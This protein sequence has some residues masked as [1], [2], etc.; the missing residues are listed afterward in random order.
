M[1]RLG[2]LLS[3]GGPNPKSSPKE[4]VGHHGHRSHG[5]SILWPAM[6]E[7]LRAKGYSKEKAARISNAAWNKKHGK[8]HP[9]SVKAVVK[10]A[11]KKCKCRA[12][13]PCMCGMDAGTATPG[14]VDHRRF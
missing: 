4:I 9:Q 8:K 7:H 3:K 11:K 12:T 6:Y 14:L 10:A 2:I 1:E 13:R 5:K